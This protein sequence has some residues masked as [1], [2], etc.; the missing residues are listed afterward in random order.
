M[1]YSDDQGSAFRP[2]DRGAEKASSRTE[3]HSDG[4]THVNVGFQ[5]SAFALFLQ[6]HQIA[7]VSSLVAPHIF[8]TLNV[9]VLLFVTASRPTFPS[10]WVPLSCGAFAINVFWFVNQY[11]NHLEIRAIEEAILRR[12]GGALEDFYIE[13]RRFNEY[14]INFRRTSI[15][16][17]IEPA[18]WALIT[19]TGIVLS[20]LL[21]F[22]T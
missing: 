1:V 2:I 3:I 21:H 22:S 13:Y 8:R 9:L 20:V 11:N 5:D 4:T 7:S 15:L 17:R 10:L 16:N 12:T 6:N 18:I 19:N 14:R